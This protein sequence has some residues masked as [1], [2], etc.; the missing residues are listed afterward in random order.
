MMRDVHCERQKK[1]E[2]RVVKKEVNHRGKSKHEKRE[3]KHTDRHNTIATFGG[4]RE[5]ER[6]RER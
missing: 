5:R 2:R 1:K 4:G 3:S 6:K